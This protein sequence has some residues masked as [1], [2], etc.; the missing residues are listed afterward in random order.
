ML[1]RTLSTKIA[2]ALVCGASLAGA[3]GAGQQSFSD[4]I[5]VQTTDWTNSVTVSKFDPAIGIL[6]SVKVTL[7][8]HIEGSIF[9]ESQDPLPQVVTTN[10]TATIELFRPDTSLIVSASPAVQHVDSVGAFDNVVDFGGSSGKTYANLSEN[11]SQSH[12][13]PPP[14]SDLVLFTGASGS[15]GTITLS[16]RAV[17]HSAATGSGNIIQGFTTQASAVVTVVYTYAPDCQPNGVGDDDDIASGTS[18]DCDLNGVPDECQAD[19]NADGVPDVCESDCNLNGIPDECEALGDCDDDGLPDICEPDCDNDGTPDECDETPCPDCESLNRQTPG[20]LLIFP[21]FDNRP[22]RTTLITVTNTNCEN[23]PEIINPG[24]DVEF[25]YIGKFGRNGED[26]EC[27]EFNRTR[28][29]T[30]CDTFTTLTNYDNP[31]QARGYLYVFAKDPQTHRPVVFN[32]LIGQELLLGGTGYLDDALNAVVFRGIGSKSGLVSR[33]AETDLDDDGIRD[34]DGHEYDRAPAQI[35]IPR[36][37]GVDAPRLNPGLGN[38]AAIRSRLI[39]LGLSGGTEFTTLIDFL[40]Y[41]D[42]E[43][44]LSTQYIFRCWDTPDLTDISNV[45][46]NQFLKNQTND[47]PN[48]IAHANRESGWMRINGRIAVSTTNFVINDPAVY[49]V[50]VE[51]ITSGHSVAELPFELCTQDNGDLLP[52]D[53]FG[54]H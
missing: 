40:V 7:D 24:I 19:C 52:T 32:H 38:T 30:P 9:F 43:E 4:S 10:L 49:A 14:P 5:P 51:H 42:N 3:V 39:L 46:L 12:T 31:T 15:P 44:V 47:D 1:F 6:Q 28:H 48:E 16:V 20:S 33:A 17:G 35:L 8:A 34:L 53:P 27:V 25:V 37:L 13:A 41:N 2:L 45:F 26:L 29:L 54:D 11:S 23:D 36:F 21:E 22:G 50:L 18:L